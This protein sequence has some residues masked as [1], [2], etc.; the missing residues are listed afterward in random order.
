MGSS[1]YRAIVA[2]MDDPLNRACIDR[3]L[4]RRGK[5]SQYLCPPVPK[6]G[7]DGCSFPTF[8]YVCR[9][10]WP[11]PRD[12]IDDQDAE[13]FTDGSKW[14]ATLTWEGDVE[15]GPFDTKA[16]GVAE[17][18]KFFATQGFV[19]LSSVPWEQEDS[20]EWRIKS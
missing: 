16:Q 10:G 13:V 15:I 20:T 8:R 11:A 5:A 6:V 2:M 3:E 14:F 12:T 7:T 17:V 4:I 19:V 9:F 1:R 18:Q